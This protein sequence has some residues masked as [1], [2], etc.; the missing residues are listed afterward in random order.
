[1]QAEQDGG[2]AEIALGALESPR[3]EE[4]LELAPRVLVVDAF[5]EHVGDEPVQLLSHGS[6]R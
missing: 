6:E 3:D 1:M 2:V 4:L 5:V